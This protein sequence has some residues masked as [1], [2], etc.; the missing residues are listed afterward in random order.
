LGEGRGKGLQTAGGSAVQCTAPSSPDAS[1]S[2]LA[3]LDALY[4]A[5]DLNAASSQRR[6]VTSAASAR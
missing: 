1:P 5:G 6:G 4:A 2:H 3:I